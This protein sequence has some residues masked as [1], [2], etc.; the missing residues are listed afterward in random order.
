MLEVNTVSPTATET[1][2]NQSPSQAY[3]Q[4]M[5]PISPAINPGSP[6]NIK[7][8]PHAWQ[9]TSPVMPTHAEIPVK[10]NRFVS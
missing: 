9:L 5:S 1:D 10:Q 8:T 4:Q 6:T 3:L 2:V 7:T